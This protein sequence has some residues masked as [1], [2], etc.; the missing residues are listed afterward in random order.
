[1]TDVAHILGEFIAAWRAGERPRAAAYLERVPES[2]R[3]ELAEQIETYMLMAPEPEY[4]DETWEE[5]V[6][7]PRVAEAA[8]AA[9]AEPE[10]WTSLLPRLR[11]RAGLSIRQVAERLGVSDRERAEQ[12]L[13][14]ME[15]G[16]LD[17]KAP[18]WTLLGKLGQILG[19]RAHQLDWRGGS[20]WTGVAPAPL[21]AYRADRP[22]ER[23]RM[24]MDIAADML[25]TDDREPDEVDELFLGGRD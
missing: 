13:S 1:M 6:S 9:F 12:R 23:A 19:V 4:S 5:M 14:E 3:D 7:D 18:T 24:H 15:Q 25:L 22:A 8:E 16:R 21:A 11:E 10:P 2:Q 20:G 17:P